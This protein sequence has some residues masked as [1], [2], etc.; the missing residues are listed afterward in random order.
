MA[1]SA[2]M[3]TIISR[4]SIRRYLPD[5]VP[6]SVIETVLTAATWAASAHNR[7]PWRFCVIQSTEQKETLA[8]A[9][10]AQLRRDLEADGTPEAIIA[11]DTGRSY[12]RITSAPV[13]IALCLSL[14]DMDHYPDAR[15]NDQEFI[16]AVQSTAMA[17][18]NLLLAAHDQGLG[19]CWMCAP[20]F[21]P[22]VVSAVLD[23]PADWQPQALITLGYPAES[24]EKTRRPLEMGVTWR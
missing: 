19:A 2:L 23:L 7:Q 10:G 24:K 5:P 6:Q 22:E 9:M 3:Q 15:R 13:L 4:R 18:Q 20:L 12:S 14:V 21:C 16:M 1:Q 17:G 11:A 8:R